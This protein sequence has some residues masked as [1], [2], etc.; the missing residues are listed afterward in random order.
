MGE[1][2]VSYCYPDCTHTL[3]RVQTLPS[4]EGC[5]LIAVDPETQKGSSPGKA[6][7]RPHPGDGSRG[8]V[9]GRQRNAAPVGGTQLREGLRQVRCLPTPAG[10]Q[11]WART[12]PSEVNNRLP[13]WGQ[14]RKLKG[15]GVE[16][17]PGRSLRAL[18]Q[19]KRLCPHPWGGVGGPSPGNCPNLRARGRGPQKASK[20]QLNH[21]LPLWLP[22][23]GLDLVHCGG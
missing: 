9:G 18:Q 21:F 6:G 5:L 17:S 19:R 12:E 3:S 1:S 7:S 15:S 14:K 20:I 8:R 23:M 11:L 13:A 22:G 2:P 10:S 16:A 4:G